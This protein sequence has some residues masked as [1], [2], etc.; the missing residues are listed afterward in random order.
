MD[1]KCNCASFGEERDESRDESRVCG[2]KGEG[3]A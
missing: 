2:G 3:G 1:F